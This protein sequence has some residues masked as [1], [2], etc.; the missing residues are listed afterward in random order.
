MTKIVIIHAGKGTHVRHG[1]VKPSLNGTKKSQTRRKMGQT[2]GIHTVGKP[3]RPPFLLPSDF[4]RLVAPMAAR[5]LFC[6]GPNEPAQGS[7]GE[8]PEFNVAAF[9]LSGNRGT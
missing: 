9:I 8:N 7:Y 6:V 1:L 3:L 5:V 2:G 4:M